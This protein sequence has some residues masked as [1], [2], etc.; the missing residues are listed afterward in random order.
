[1]RV[2]VSGCRKANLVVIL[3]LL[4]AIAL[5][6]ADQDLTTSDGL[7][8][9]QLFLVLGYAA[10]PLFYGGCAFSIWKMASLYRRADTLLTMDSSNLFVWGKEIPLREISSVSVERGPLFSRQLVI[11]RKDGTQRRISS[12]A[13]ASPIYEVADRL[14]AAARVS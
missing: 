4:G 11:A 7:K 6:G 3:T 10:Y 1:M 2:V 5:Y 9:T 14:K 12:V 8:R 13:L